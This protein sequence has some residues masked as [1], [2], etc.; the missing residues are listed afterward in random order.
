MRAEI[1]GPLWWGIDVW[2]L[3]WCG[4]N[5]EEAG[6]G[7]LIIIRFKEAKNRRTNL[8]CKALYLHKK[9]TVYKRSTE[10]NN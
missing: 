5:S 4:R 7:G 1:R 9:K 10:S 2:W 8:I 6:D 3:K